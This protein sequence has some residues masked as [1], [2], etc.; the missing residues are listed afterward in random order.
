MTATLFDRARPPIAERFEAF[1]RENPHVADI[2]EK[3]AD[4]VVAAGCS[5]FGVKML[6]EVM[7]YLLIVETKRDL[8][9]FR[10][11]NDY[12]S[13]YARLLIERRPEWAGK[14]ETRQLKGDA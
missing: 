4:N 8:G 11:N 13:R 3:L 9:D 1:H 10:L 2:L 12:H 5:R 14:I 7:R 6:W